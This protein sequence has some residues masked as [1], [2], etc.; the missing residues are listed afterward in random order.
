MKPKS[1]AQ[2]EPKYP[3]KIVGKK[4]QQWLD[5]VGGKHHQWLGEKHQQWLGGERQRWR[6]FSVLSGSWGGWIF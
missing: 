5:I 4:H 6:K 1:L 2:I 3:K